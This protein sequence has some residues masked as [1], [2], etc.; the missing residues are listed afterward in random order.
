MNCPVKPPPPHSIERPPRVGAQTA[1]GEQERRRRAVEVHAISVGGLNLLLV[2]IWFLTSR[3]YFWPMWTLLVCGLALTIHA[4]V[5]W[6]GEH[7]AYWLE[8]R[9]DHGSRSTRA[10]GRRCCCS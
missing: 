5:I 6:S 10:C 2:L 7:R 4:W 1:A 8:H 9:L 3:G